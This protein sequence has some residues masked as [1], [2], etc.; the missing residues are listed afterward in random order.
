M[1]ILII[2]D[3]VIL[4]DALSKILNIHNHNV[5]TINDGAIGLSKFI[6]NRDTIDYVILDIMMPVL[7]GAQIYKIIRKLGNVKVII[8]TGYTLNDGELKSEM[9]SNKNTII[10]KKPFDMNEILHIIQ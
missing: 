3:D 4:S 10:L 1:N 9:Y 6:E 8:V 7:D 2:D 5:T